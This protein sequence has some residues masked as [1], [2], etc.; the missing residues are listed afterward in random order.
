MGRGKGGCGRRGGKGGEWAENGDRNREG[1]YL[2]R[3]VA[4]ILGGGWGYK[5]GGGESP[6]NTSRNGTRNEGMTFL[7]CG[8]RRMRAGKDRIE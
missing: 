4:V 8:W 1:D 2:G 3:W 5:S 6:T 7:V